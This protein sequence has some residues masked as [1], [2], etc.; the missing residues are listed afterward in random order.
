MAGFQVSIY[1]RF[2]VSTEVVVTDG[3]ADPLDA[4]MGGLAAYRRTRPSDNFPL[5]GL[6]DEPVTDLQLH[7]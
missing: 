3:I 4:S 6:V 1:G 7:R 2:W 5:A